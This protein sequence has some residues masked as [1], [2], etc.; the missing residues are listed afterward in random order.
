[1]CCVERN[2]AIFNTALVCMT[3]VVETYSIYSTII[4][5]LYVV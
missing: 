5:M 3:I 2:G 4:Y 1:M